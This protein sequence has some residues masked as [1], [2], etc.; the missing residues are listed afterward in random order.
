MDKIKR[1][2]IFVIIIA[3]TGSC[4]ISNRT[5]R[6]PN[7]HI[8]FY[9]EDFTYSKQV[10][11]SAI[12]KRVLGIDWKRFFNWKT[13]EIKTSGVSDKTTD[14]KANISITQ[15][16]IVG[17]LGVP[18]IPVLGQYAKGETGAYALYKLMQK[19]PGYDVVIYPQYERHHFIIPLI[20]SKHEVTV[21]AR[22]GK[23]KQE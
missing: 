21:T 18:T 10:S 9:K 15:G 17:T 23:I 7:H 13:G 5:M 2:L 16:P 12:S 22:L 4:S 6:S 8:E 14:P 3:L 19:H 11:A 1:T 20:Y